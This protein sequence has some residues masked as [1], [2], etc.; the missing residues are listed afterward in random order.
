MLPLKVFNAADA[1]EIRWK[2][3]GVTIKPGKDL[4]YMIETSGVLEAYVF[5]EDESTD[6][7]IKNIRISDK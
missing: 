5:W 2:Y 6:V 7:I 3:N 1:K 4:H